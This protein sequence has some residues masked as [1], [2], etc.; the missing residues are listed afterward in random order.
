M[1]GCPNLVWEWRETI[2]HDFE[3]I[4]KENITYQ[5]NKIEHLI[6]YQNTTRKNL[7]HI[8]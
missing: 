2:R 6:N 3:M 1:E 5:N 8:I 7:C 4:L